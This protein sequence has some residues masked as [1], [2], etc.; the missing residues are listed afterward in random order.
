MTEE[1][2]QKGLLNDTLPQD[3]VEYKDDPTGSNGIFGTMFNLANTIIGSGTLAIPLAFQFSGYVGGPVLLLVAWFLSAF[4]MYLLTYVCVKTHMWTY[5]EI[6]EKIGGKWLSYLVQISIFC[7]T[8]GTCI[9]YPIFLGGFMPHIFSTF[10]PRTILVD[11][12]FDIM[13][14]G[15]CVVYPLSMFKNLSALKYAS[16]LCLVCVIYTTI[17]TI[18]E[19]FTTYFDNFENN[20][21]V[22]FNA[23]I[24]FL[25]GF[26]YMTCAFTA[27]YNVLRFY[28]ELK[29]RS[30]KKMNLIVLVSTFVS[31]LVYLLIGLFG[32]FSLNPN[33]TGNI[34]VDYPTSDI[35]MFIACISFCLVMSLSF[36]LV[37]HA[38]RDIFDKLVFAGWEDSQ[39]RRVSLSLILIS[40]CMFLAAAVEQISTVLAYNGSIFGSLVVYIFPSV[41]AFKVA[42]GPLKWISLGIFIIGIIMGGIGLGITIANQF[43]AFD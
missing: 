16:L 29:G 31:F 42:K 43:N 25:R 32:Y 19:T 34:L 5:K 35:P 12:H 36:P 1:G 23:D 8:T 37:H 4:A 39:V 7:Y 11:R 9:A 22:W 10:A 13:I 18:I 26:P 21:P 3:E 27:H 41:F 24:Q 20:P 40:V 2:Q 6:S 15:F 17:T 14:I 28:S 33:L 30:I 38:Q